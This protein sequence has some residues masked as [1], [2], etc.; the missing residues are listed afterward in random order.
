MTSVTKYKIY[1]NTENC[2]VEGYG[3]SVPTACYNNRSHDVNVN[4]VQ[5]LETINSSNVIVQEEMGPYKTQ[6][7]FAATP[8][9]FT[10]APNTSTKYITQFPY[11]INMMTCQL[12]VS[13]DMVGD[14][15]TFEIAN[16]TSIGTIADPAS[17]GATSVVVNT[18]ALAHL[19]LG[20]IIYITDGTNTSNGGRVT[21]MN[22]STATITFETALSNSY[23]AGS[24]VQFTRRYVDN[25]SIN[26]SGIHQIGYSKIGG[27]YV[28]TGV[29]GCA[30]YLNTSNTP[31][32]VTFILDHLY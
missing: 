16:N 28:P 12:Q 23:N 9:T 14:A 4:S 31:K 17:N 27:S 22:T 32:K 19:F 8:F 26:V 13:P 3:T 24:V 1:C 15:I 29:N 30:T 6:G 11:P 5:A 18:T 2:F 10:A 20:A 7:Y 21:G 25:Y